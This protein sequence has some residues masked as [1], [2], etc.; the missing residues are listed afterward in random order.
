MRY[1]NA[2]LA[3]AAAESR[4]PRLIEDPNWIAEQ[5][6]DGQRCLMH[7]ENE[8]I[9]PITRTGRIL[10]VS[11]PCMNVFMPFVRSGHRWVFDGEYL[12]GVYYVFDMIE[13]ATM[14]KPSTPLG[15][16]RTALETFWK[17]WNPSASDVAL[18]PAARTPDEKERLVT[19]VRE[20]GGE[21][22]MFKRLDSKYIEGKRSSSI[23]K[24]KWRNDADCV[25]MSLGSDGKDNMTL[26]MYD[27]AGVLVPVGECTALAGDGPKVKPDDVVTVIYQYASENDRLIMPTYPRIRTDKPRNECTKAQLVYANKSVFLDYQGEP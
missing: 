21:G 22:V 17:Q 27:E 4:L 25:V 7:I 24:I 1:M 10:T 16:R 11:T 2:M 5:K 20:A 9:A 23:L 12:N 3:E 14:I 18:L 6:I 13:A 26:G 19:H 8:R 15:D